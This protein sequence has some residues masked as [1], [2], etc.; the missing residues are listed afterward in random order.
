MSNYLVRINLAK[1]PEHFIYNVKGKTAT[2]RCV[3]FPLDMPGIHFTSEK[4]ITL[5]LV[6]FEY[7]ERKFSDTH[8]VKIS[9]DKDVYNAMS[10]E[11]K[12][13]LPIIGGIRPLLAERKP[14]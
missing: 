11:E 14:T 1:I 13:K 4:S 5:D 7:R 8:M 3:C 12:N 6:A 9:I 2:K 10:D